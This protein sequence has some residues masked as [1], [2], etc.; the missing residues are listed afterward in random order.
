MDKLNL[1][2]KPLHVRKNE[3]IGGG[4][5]VFRRGNYAGRIKPSEK[6]YEFPSL[7]AAQEEQK[8]LTAA[9]G[10]VYD[11]LCVVKM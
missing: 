3:V 4:Y 2:G 8:R 1:R 6:P 7:L 5:F 10:G 11:V 9:Y